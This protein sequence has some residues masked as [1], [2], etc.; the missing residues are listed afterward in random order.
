MELTDIIKILTMALSCK[1]R[2]KMLLIE[3]Q[4]LEDNIFD[5]LVIY[6]GNI[7][8]TINLLSE[9]I[10]THYENLNTVECLEI[11]KKVKNKIDD[12]AII[13]NHLSRYVSLAVH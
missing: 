11:M 6:A 13:E 9:I 5:A 7:I 3:N 12:S 4:Y 2:A 8:E 10:E 1:S